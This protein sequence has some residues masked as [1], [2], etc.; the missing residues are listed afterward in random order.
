[1]NE[2]ELRQRE[3]TTVKKTKTKTKR[4]QKGQRIISREKMKPE[5]ERLRE[6]HGVSKRNQGD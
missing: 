6:F 4:S 3:R 2:V 5:T 1:M